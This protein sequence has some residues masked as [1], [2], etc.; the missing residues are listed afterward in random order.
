MGRG[1]GGLPLRQSLPKNTQDFMATAFLA[2]AVLRRCQ[3]T[4]F[5]L[6]LRQMLA[7][8]CPAGRYCAPA[9]LPVI[10]PYIRPHDRVSQR[11]V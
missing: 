4:A 3:P 8:L 1:L 10:W 5:L 2:V 6:I 7:L 9:A 11:I